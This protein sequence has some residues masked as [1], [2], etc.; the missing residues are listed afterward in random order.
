MYITDAT[1]FLDETGAI[2]PQSGPGRK[3]ADF[4]GTVIVAATLS[5]TSATTPLCF[6]C[7]GS[8]TAH[9]PAG[10]V[11]EWQC[12]GCGES[13]RITNWAGTLWDMTAS[14]NQPVVSH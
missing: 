1:H 3:M 7:S 14:R 11:I 12:S 6:K 4:L 9:A 5:G 10:E 8:V 13:G 2:G